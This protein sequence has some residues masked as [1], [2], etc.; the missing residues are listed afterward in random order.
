MRHEEYSQQLLTQRQNFD[1][2]GK[3]LLSNARIFKWYQ[4]WSGKVYVAFSGGKD[5]TVLLH[6][7]R[8]QFPEVPG[9]FID[10]GLEYPEIREFVKTVDN[11]IV[12]KPEMQFKKVIE[13]YG[14]PL[15]SKIQAEYI[16][17]QRSKTT[18]KT[19]RYNGLHLRNGQKK[20]K[21]SEKWKY[22]LNAPFKISAKCCKHLKK[23]PAKLY[24]K[25][26]GLKPILGIL[27]EESEQRRDQYVKKGCNIY[28]GDMPQSRPMM[29]WKTSDIW[30]YI[31]KYNIP[32]SDIYDKGVNR[33]GCIFCLF[34]I[35][36][37]NH[38]NRFDKLKQLH[39]KLYDYCMVN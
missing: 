28:D 20:Y 25:E 4:E 10:T 19:K 22:L 3:I 33:T 31:K 29:F 21:I 30:D 37:E 16:E 9:V 15:I 13:K 12:I 32:Y 27:A 34:G 35:H 17:D 24:E 14:Y 39:P 18:M 1:L 23:N 26:T 7:V 38:P 5:S 6:L 11:V 36:M 8:Q 2:E